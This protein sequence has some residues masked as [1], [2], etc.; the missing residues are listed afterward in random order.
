MKEDNDHQQT[1][2]LSQSI[3]KHSTKTRPTP[4]QSSDAPP[5]PILRYEWIQKLRDALITSKTRNFNSKPSKH[6][7]SI[8]QKLLHKST[9]RCLHHLMVDNSLNTLC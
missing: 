8:T 2:W 3:E 1:G 4:Q 9:N 5:S 7:T 6:V